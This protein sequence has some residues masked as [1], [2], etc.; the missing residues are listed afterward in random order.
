MAFTINPGVLAI[1]GVL[2]L[3]IITTSIG[4]VGLSTR[5][6]NPMFQAYYLPTNTPQTHAG[7]NI[8][9]SVFVTNTFQLQSNANETLI[10]DA[11][12]YRYDL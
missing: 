4:A 1:A 5:D 6:Q 11:E 12:N 7:W 8:S 3:P 9:H 2:I 10:I